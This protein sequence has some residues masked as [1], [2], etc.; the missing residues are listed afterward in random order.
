MRAGSCAISSSSL[1]PS[2]SRDGSAG[3]APN[4]ISATGSPVTGRPHSLGM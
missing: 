2:S 1:E 3:W 4:H